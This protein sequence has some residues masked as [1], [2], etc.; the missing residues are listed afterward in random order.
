MKGTLCCLGILLFGGRILTAQEPSPQSLDF[1]AGDKPDPAAQP[2]SLHVEGL[3]GIPNSAAERGRNAR[4]IYVSKVAAD[5]YSSRH[6]QP[7]DVILGVNA[8]PFEGK[9]IDTFREAVADAA[10][11]GKGGNLRL[12]RWRN[13]EQATLDFLTLP[14]PPDLTRGEKKPDIPDW[15]LGPTGAKGWIFARGFDT[16]DARQIL[17]NGV[18]KGSPADGVLE[19]GDVILGIGGKMFESDARQAFGNAITEAEKARN[20][21]ALKLTLWRNGTQ[22]AVTVP[23]KVMGSHSDASPFSCSKAN[24]IVAQGCS[25]ILKRGIGDGIP[26]ALNALA[27]L[28][29]GDPKYSDAIKAYAHK[30]G[31][32]D[33]NLKMQE[34]MYAWSW[35]YANLF[36][37]EYYLATKDE[38]VLPAI[39]EYAVKM[40]RGQGAVGTWGHGLRVEGNNGTLGG[41][42]AI[43]QSGLI[44]WMSLVLAQKCGIDDP[45]VRRAVAK[46]HEFFSFYVGKGSIPY[47]DHPPYSILH[48]DNGKSGSAAITFDL[49]NDQPSAR[50]FSR[51]A[52][53]AYAEKEMGHTGNYFSFLWGALGAN[54]AGPKAAAAYMKELRWYYDMARRWDGSFFTIGRDNYNWDMTGLFV[55]HYELPLQ[56]LYITGKGVS[57]ANELAEKELQEVLECGKGFS[58]GKNDYAY[59]SKQD[60][61]LLAAL[62]SWSPVVRHRAASAIAK[63]DANLVPQLIFL[64]SEKDLNF[65]YGACLAL[66]YLEER[67]APATDELIRQLSEKDMWLRTRAAF[68]LN[69][70]GRPARKAVPE[71]LKLALAVDQQDP[72]GLQCKYLAFALFRAGFVDNLPRPRGLLADSL[73]G[74]DRDLLYPVIRRL[75]ASD[76]GLCT[77]AMCSIFKTLNTDELKALLPSIVQ[78]AYNAPPSGEMFAQEI[79]VDAMKF[80]ATNRIPEGLPVFIEYARTQNGWGQK[81]TQ[82]L[83]LLKE[84]GPGARKILPELKEL[85]TTWKAQE[86]ERKQGGVTKSGVAD[87]VIKAIESAR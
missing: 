39:R 63:R 80:M 8:K 22:T 68:A 42:G 14:P 74:V 47:G 35:S 3:S 11:R 16:S 18:E 65:R 71:M 24:L 57:R 87:D 78:V 46:S 12:I 54:R 43:N 82:I 26:G 69:G 60:H 52:T 55:L 25:N 17:V 70:I 86:T 81:T 62:G 10:G 44:C 53:A 41:Y 56:K 84:Y 49:L 40:S 67:A 85:S 72:R 32:P 21:G 27:L 48:D 76:D 66:Q 15:N 79:R 37:T 83:P 5:S 30:N 28:A 1:T 73:E 20:K 19:K 2:F 50:F 75:L 58:Y 23:L 9:V 45:D 33:L 34:G 7:G 59:L 6:L 77:Y 29:S 61:Q 36:L 4:Q 13:G 38:Y 51:L 64:L 31:P